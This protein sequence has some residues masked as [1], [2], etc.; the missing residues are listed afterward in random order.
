MTSPNSPQ[1]QPDR[2]VIASQGHPR[3]VIVLGEQPSPFYCWLGL[4]LQRYL[5]QLSGTEMPI[6]TS[7]DIPADTNLLVVG[8]PASHGLVRLFCNREDRHP[9]AMKPGGYLIAPATHAGRPAL[10][11]LGNDEQATMYAVYELLEQLGIVFQLTGDLIPEVKPELYF[12]QA[13]VRREPALKYRG[14]HIRHFVMPWMGMD[15]FRRLLDQLAKMR[16][17]YLE[18]Y[19]YVGS[20]WF[21]YGNNA[22]EKKL[23]GDIYTA[24]SGFTS[25]RLETGTFTTRDVVIG[26]EQFHDERPCAPEFQHC[27]TQEEA[28]RTARQLLTRVINYAHSRK[29]EVWLG[30]GDCP[31]V[32]AN[33]GR[34]A[35]FGQRTGAFGR[36]ISARPAGDGDLD[37]HARI[38][39]P[40]LSAG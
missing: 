15:Y 7:G 26:R 22:G 25:W 18:F 27:R 2:P 20:P 32:P 29:I 11:L 13:A 36:I 14:L 10:F 40:R 37:G 38:H 34:H 8:D 28:Y 17:N 16:C 33:L 9:G 19:A 21:E 1:P 35:R 4:E 31:G 24:E 30:K 23:L 6:T 3:A 39:D 12:P 5:R